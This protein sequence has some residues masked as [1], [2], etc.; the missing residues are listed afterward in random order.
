MSFSAQAQTP[1]MPYTLVYRASRDAADV[2][3]PWVNKLHPATQ[4]AYYFNPETKQSSSEH[5][6]RA[7]AATL[8]SSSSAP[9]DGKKRSLTESGGNEAT[10]KKGRALPADID[11][12]DPTGGE[13]PHTLSS[14]SK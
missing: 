6:L 7:A 14:P 11:P 9:P 3:H 10:R 5:P 12:L 13:V 8:P 1:G 4:Q 2:P